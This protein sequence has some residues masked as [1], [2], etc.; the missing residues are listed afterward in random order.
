MAEGERPE[1]G[2]HDWNKE[3]FEETAKRQR[4]EQSREQAEV[5]QQ[6][7]KRDIGSHIAELRREA[8]TQLYKPDSAIS[9]LD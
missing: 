5:I 1:S 6:L 3:G 8:E 9:G 2:S 4:A 7:R